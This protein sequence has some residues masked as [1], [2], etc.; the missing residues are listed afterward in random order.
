M[1]QSSLEKSRTKTATSF[2][3]TA[4]G[5]SEKAGKKAAKP[6]TAKTGG[7]TKQSEQAAK[8]LKPAMKK[9]PPQH[10][11]THSRLIVEVCI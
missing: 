1:G 2:D 8:V 5:R 6:T 10:V 7:G 11:H 9:A 4:S 3:V